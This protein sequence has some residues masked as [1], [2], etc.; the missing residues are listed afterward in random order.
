MNLR[1][2]ILIKMTTTTTTNNQKSVVLESSVKPSPGS[3]SGRQDV[4]LT[5]DS[6]TDSGY[7]LVQSGRG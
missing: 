2:A 6:R 4:G 5:E 3:Q 1:L 7:K